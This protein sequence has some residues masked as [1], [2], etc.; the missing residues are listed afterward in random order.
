MCSLPPFFRKKNVSFV[1]NFGTCPTVFPLFITAMEYLSSTK[2]PCLASGAVA[3]LTQFQQSFESG[4]YYIPWNNIKHWKQEFLNPWQAVLLL[5]NLP[6]LSFA[7]SAT[8]REFRTTV[9]IC[10]AMQ[11]YQWK[12]FECLFECIDLNCISMFRDIHTIF[13][14]FTH[15]F[16]YNFVAKWQLKLTCLV[17]LVKLLLEKE[18]C[19]QI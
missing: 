12:T 17:I 19:N 18:N 6:F 13:P 15:I 8:F 16:V 11:C 10:N 5:M 4:K 14:I 9:E 1:K 2:A 7:L 3:N